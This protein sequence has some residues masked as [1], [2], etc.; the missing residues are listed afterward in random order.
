M[1][2][3]TRAVVCQRCGL[4]FVLTVTYRDFLAR[5]GVKVKTPLLC[6]TCFLKTGP[7]SKQRGEVKWFD[8]R[9]RYGFIVTKEG[10]EIFFHRRQVLKNNTDEP[11]EGQEVLF[12]SRYARKGPEAVNVELI[13]DR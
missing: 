10:E 6:T 12:H 9:K 5:R 11:R 4:G 7:L 3:L 8:S 13:Y 1:S 2:D